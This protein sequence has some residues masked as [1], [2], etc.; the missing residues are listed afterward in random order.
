MTPISLFHRYACFVPCTTGVP[1]AS[2]LDHLICF[3]CALSTGLVDANTGAYREATLA[4]VA[5]VERGRESEASALSKGWRSSRCARCGFGMAQ[6]D[7]GAR[8]ARMLLPEGWSPLT[9]RERIT[10][11]DDRDAF[12]AAG[13]LAGA[14]V[15]A[16]ATDGDWEFIARLVTE[17]FAWNLASEDD[18]LRAIGWVRGLRYTLLPQL[19]AVWAKG[20]SDLERRLREAR[21]AAA[22]SGIFHDFSRCA[23]NGTYLELTGW[24]ILPR[25]E[26]PGCLRANTRDVSW[27]DYSWIIGDPPTDEVG[28]LSARS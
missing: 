20:G 5:R 28:R 7:L 15:A 13:R 3:D 8:R 14:L 25:S 19:V 24:H 12:L 1:I 17:D 2:P 6:I 26:L 23:L 27:T 21:K 4:A 9:D 10:R 18:R 22:D 16:D 11:I